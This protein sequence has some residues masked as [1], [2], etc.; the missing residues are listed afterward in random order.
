M[1]VYRVS[2]FPRVLI[3]GGAGFIGSNLVKNL[4]L[5]G[6]FVDCIDNFVTGRESAVAP[7]MRNA[8]FRFFRGDISDTVFMSRFAGQPY[9]HIYN[10]AC[11]TGVP[12]IALLGEEMLL[13]SSLGSLNLLHIAEATNARYL[14]ASTAEIYGDPEI[15]P[16]PETYSGNVDPV[17]P[18]S[19]YEEGKRFGEALTVHFAR[20]R[21]VDAR[22]IRIF[23][24]FG[25][26]MSVTDTRVIPQM[27]NRMAMGKTVTIFGDGG[28]TR[29]FLHVDDLVAAFAITMQRNCK[30]DVYNVG[31]ETEYTI[32]ELFELCSGVADYHMRPIFKPHF[33]NDHRRRLPD[34]RKIRS[35]GWH[36]KMQLQEGLKAS[37]EALRTD[38]LRYGEKHNSGFSRASQRTSADPAHV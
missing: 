1:S 35:L 18:R 5:K 17:G 4:L 38:L 9:S 29:S 13:T 10:L 8:R 28:N 12:N 36:P 24:T 14:F 7:F 2:K 30:G 21:H 25:P 33:I 6:K 15:F 11:P 16:Q 22:I 26:N 19:A 20:H 23:N 34:T 37:Y 27:L 32:A 31:G 3:A